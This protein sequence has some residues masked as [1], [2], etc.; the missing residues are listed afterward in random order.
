MG[1]SFS[2]APPNKAQ[3]SSAIYKHINDLNLNNYNML[4]RIKNKILW[5]ILFQLNRQL[6]NN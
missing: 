3:V 2:A 6:Y 1:Y 4:F 5:Q